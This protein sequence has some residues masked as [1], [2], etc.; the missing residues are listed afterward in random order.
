M[1]TGRVNQVIPYMCIRFFASKVTGT[2]P[3][4]AYSSISVAMK[5]AQQ[6]Q[7]LKVGIES[8]TAYSNGMNLS[9]AY[10]LVQSDDTFHYVIE[11]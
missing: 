8:L 5:M 11:R 10:L 9:L 1:T 4:Q 3:N 2:L 7:M 6:K